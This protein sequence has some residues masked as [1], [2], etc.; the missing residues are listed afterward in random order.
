MGEEERNRPPYTRAK[1]FVTKYK[2]SCYC[3]SVKWD[4]AADALDAMYC[5]CNICQTLHGTPYQWAAVMKKSDVHFYEGGDRLIFYYSNT[6]E[7]VYT[8]PCK[9]SC[10]DCHAPVADEGR[11]MMLMLPPYVKFEK[12]GT[13]R[14]QIPIAFQAQHHMFY[15]D[16]VADM[17]DGKEKFLGRKGEDPCDDQGN[18]L[19]KPKESGGV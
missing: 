6:K 18:P 9:L 17:N 7:N 19:S 1:G 11:N 15:G 13:G 12:D 8:L 5:H 2:A 3:G 10:P 16:R 14:K 4:L